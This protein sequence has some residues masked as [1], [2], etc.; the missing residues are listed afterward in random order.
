MTNGN[1]INK[2]L[3]NIN[4]QLVNS[5]SS[6][7]YVTLFYGEIDSTT[8]IFHFSNAGHNYPILARANGDIELL[9]TGGPVVGALPMMTYE[10][11]SV[12]LNKDDMLFLFTDGL[13][14]AMDA[15]ENEYTEE[16]IRKF[17]CDH[18]HEHPEK[19]ID[20]ILKDVRKHD[21]T[22]PPRDDTTIVAL[23]VNNNF[24]LN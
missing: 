17:I 12:K 3:R 9:K 15:D 1:P 22:F 7:K 2:V 5:S 18:R 19:I 23:H 8:G 13:S 6:E 16:R 20:G 24:G 4:N 11:E 21:P 14:E 10:S